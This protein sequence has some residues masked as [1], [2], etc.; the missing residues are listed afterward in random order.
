MRSVHLGIVLVLVR[1]RFC[2]RAGRRGDLCRRG[3]LVLL[4][5]PLPFL[6]FL[7]LVACCGGLREGGGLFSWMFADMV[8]RLGS[9]F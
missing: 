5:G 1:R 9:V 2:S 8:S 4:V 7:V 6:V 3:V